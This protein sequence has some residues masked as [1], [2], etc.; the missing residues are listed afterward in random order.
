MTVMRLRADFFIRIEQL[1]G[2]AANDNCVGDEGFTV[3]NLVSAQ[4]TYT[5]AIFTRDDGA[6]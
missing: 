3:R 6:Q 5:L 2:L 4:L 1:Q